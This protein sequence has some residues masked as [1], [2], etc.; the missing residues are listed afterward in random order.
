M[1]DGVDRGSAFGRWLTADRAAVDVLLAGAL[2]RGGDREAVRAAV[3]A[4]AGAFRG[5]DE[6]DPGL[7]RA[8]VA[9][10]ADL[11]ARGRW[12]ADGPDRAVVLDVLP[13]LTGLAHSQPTAT[14]DA[15]A[16]AG[17]TVARTGDLALFGSLLA[18]VPAV[19]DPSVV[20]ATVL[21]ASWRSGAARYRTAALREA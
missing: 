7:G 13:R 16:A 5:V 9:H 14:V 10:V 11:A 6:L 4:V 15:V 8:L 1:S 3:V 21:V 20:R 19:E 2:A 12:R 17:R 18:A